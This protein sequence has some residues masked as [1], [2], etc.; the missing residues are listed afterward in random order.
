MNLH[1]KIRCLTVIALLFCL[2]LSA[3]SC[4]KTQTSNSKQVINRM[5]AFNNGIFD[6]SGLVDVP[7]TDGVLFVDNK[8]RGQVLW[9]SFER[10]SRQVN[11]IKAIDLGVGIEDPEGMTADGTHFYVV[12]SQSKP[13][14]IAAEG[15]VR[16]KFDP[17]SKSI[18]GVESINGLK[19]FLV[20]NVA[21]LH[22]KGHIKGKDG[23][24]NIEGF[25]WD[26]KNERLLLGLRSPIVDGHALVIPL[27]LRDPKGA[28]SVENLE[29]Q[30]RKAIRLPLG[31]SG[32]RGIEYDG[33]TKA[34]QIISGASGDQ[35]K[36]DFIIWE[37]NGNTQQ[38]ALRETH[39]FDK[40]L[41][42]EG[43][44]RATVGEHHFTLVVFDASGYTIVN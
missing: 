3:L 17:H 5:T 41:K 30:D 13:K 8:R 20:E 14:A 26:S 28:F 12:S 44:A 15:L 19:T 24:I 7:G 39:R 21:E 25:A 40:D 10:N 18:S 2:S 36:T 16:F 9:M 37:W 1:L 31:G 6:A 35:E 29:V 23:G 34:F 33:R 43:V 38:P 27:R 11:E 32:V 22:G 4:S 42:P